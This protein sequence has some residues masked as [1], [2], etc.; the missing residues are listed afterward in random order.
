MSV[1]LKPITMLRP[2]ADCIYAPS[3]IRPAIE[4]TDEKFIEMAENA[5]TIAVSFSAD[6]KSRPVQATVYSGVPGGGRFII[7]E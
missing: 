6:K 7:W 4:V 1:L 5:T 3:S 2:T